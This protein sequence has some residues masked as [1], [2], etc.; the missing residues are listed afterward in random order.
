MTQPGSRR[1]AAGAP[2]A[3]A[4]LA[5]LA[6]CASAHAE[7]PSGLAPQIAALPPAAAAP[8][9]VPW[10]DP[11]SHRCLALTV[12]FEGRSESRGVRRAIAHVVLNRVADDRFPKTICGVVKQG[13]TR[14]HACQFSWWCDGKSDTP[15]NRA[16]WEEALEIARLATR[17]D[18]PD[19]TGGALYFHDGSVAPAWSRQLRRTATIGTDRFYR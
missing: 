16:A 4:M 8:V 19:A 6:G 18:D 17:P 11:D 2:A 14:R 1:F 13:G 10:L 7:D 15:Y 3:L 9:P 12:Y 5:V